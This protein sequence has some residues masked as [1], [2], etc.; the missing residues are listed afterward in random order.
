MPQKTDSLTSVEESTHR[1]R[2]WGCTCGCLTFLV[3]ILL[4][5]L[6][7]FYLALKPYPL[8]KPDRWLRGETI[9]FGV[10]RMS[11]T[12]SGISDLFGFLSSRLEEKWGRELKDNDR[13][14]LHSLVTLA[15]QSTDWV[16]YPPVYFYLEQQK[17]GAALRFAGVGQF[18]HFFG[19]LLGRSLI[20]TFGL[21]VQSESPSLVVYRLGPREKSDAPLLGV[22]HFRLALTNDTALL[23]AVATTAEDSREASSP[24]ERF[25]TYYGE[26]HAE[27]PEPGEDFALVLINKDDALAHGLENFLKATQQIETWER[28]QETLAKHNVS[29]EDVQ[30]LRLSID[31]VSAD[32]MKC[33]AT[34]YVEQQAALKRMAEA[35]KLLEGLASSAPQK[36]NRPVSTKIESRPGRNYVEVSIELVGLRTLIDTWLGDKPGATSAPEPSSTKTDEIITSHP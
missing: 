17:S 20:Q 25:M 24:D 26:L 4:G 31:I 15:R 36:A 16:I 33:V 7:F 34:F 30:G 14:A 21:P 18:R 35:A 6:G 11:S 32:R 19:Y 28:I 27:K 2:R 22:S 13:R 3:A 5:A 29:F 8:P 10:L 1:Q 9:G 12:D 23:E